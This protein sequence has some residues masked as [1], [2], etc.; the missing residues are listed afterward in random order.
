MGKKPSKD[1]IPVEPKAPA[2]RGKP[3]KR[4][5]EIVELI[6]EGIS[7]GKTLTSLCEATEMPHVQTWYDW[8]E[9][10]AELSIRFARA[11]EK[12]YD[13]IAEE[14]LKIAD[15]TALDTI[16]TEQGKEVCNSEWIARSRLRVDTRLKLLAK[17]SPKKYGDKMEV[18]QTLKV[19]PITYIGGDAN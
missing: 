4:T 7:N 14:C 10:D 12:G 16:D 3:S 1:I 15:M 2:K 6:L 19:Q 18:E 17:W 9:K 11:R 5:P 13:V 8:L